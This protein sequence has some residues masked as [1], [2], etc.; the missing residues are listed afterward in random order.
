MISENTIILGPITA[1]LL[2]P[3]KVYYKL[4]FFVKETSLIKGFNVS[5][6]S[7]TIS[8]HYWGLKESQSKRIK[9]S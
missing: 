8:Q 4:W 3:S 7:L 9:D 1:V 5:I 2:N 6:P